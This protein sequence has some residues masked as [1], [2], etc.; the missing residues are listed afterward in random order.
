M[1]SLDMKR[2]IVWVIVA[3]AFSRIPLN[4][5]A[6]PHGTTHFVVFLSGTNEVP[7]NSSPATGEGFFELDG[8]VVNFTIGNFNYA[9]NPTSAGIYGPARPGKNG[10]LIVG[11]LASGISPPEGLV[12]LGGF[13]LTKAEIAQLKAGLWYVSVKSA[14]FPNGEIR[15]QILPDTSEL[16]AADPSDSAS[17][18]AK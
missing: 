5:Q 11:D 6:D 4:V 15:G 8:N 18:S 13:G 16:A 9:I 14:Q 3:L 10:P 7:P 17:E 1:K 2:L 12:Y